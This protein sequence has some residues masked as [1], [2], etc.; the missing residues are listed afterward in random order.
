M[1]AHPCFT[2]LS[3]IDSATCPI[4][5]CGVKATAACSNCLRAGPSAFSPSS[6]WKPSIASEPTKR[7][8][9]PETI[10]G[11]T[12]TRCTSAGAFIALTLSITHCPARAE[13]A[14]PSTASSN[15]LIPA[16]SMVRM[17]TPD[18]QAPP[19]MVRF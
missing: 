7:R 17:A 5:I 9:S 19:L 13:H 6:R 11:C 14:D 10:A 15:L 8:T 18:F 1:L 12:V 3:T 2:A 16:P 4:R